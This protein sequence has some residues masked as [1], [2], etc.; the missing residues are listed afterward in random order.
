MPTASKGPRLWLRKARR[1][2][3]GRIT[4]PAVYVIRDGRFQESTGCGRDDRDGAE[5]QLEIYLN[6]KHLSTAK[7]G[8]RDPD[9]IPVADVLAQYGA[10]IAPTHSRPK[11]TAQRIHRLLGF[12]GDKT[13]RG[14]W[15]PLP[16]IHGPQNDADGSAKRPRDTPRRDQSSPSGR[17]LRQDRQR[18]CRK[19]R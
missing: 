4:H 16:I 7:I 17:S 14:Q 1:D 2:R 3:R 19:S 12:F 13:D 8:A 6:S 15:R 11:E 10:D 18:G 9:R 5:K